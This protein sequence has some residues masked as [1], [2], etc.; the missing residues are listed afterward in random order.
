MH[1]EKKVLFY[2]FSPGAKDYSFPRERRKSFFFSFFP[3]DLLG[4]TAQAAEK[5]IKRRKKAFNAAL[6]REERSRCRCQEIPALRRAIM[7]VFFERK[8]PADV[9]NV[10]LS[11]R[12]KLS[13]FF[14][15][16]VTFPPSLYRQYFWAPFSFADITPLFPK[17][18]KGRALHFPFL[19]RRYTVCHCTCFWRE[20]I[21]AALATTHV[22]TPKKKEREEPKKRE[23]LLPLP[24]RYHFLL[25]FS[26]NRCLFCPEALLSLLR[27]N[28]LFPT[29]VTQHQ[30]KKGTGKWREIKVGQDFG[31][32]LFLPLVTTPTQILAGNSVFASWG[33]HFSPFFTRAGKNCGVGCTLAVFFSFSFVEGKWRIAASRK[34]NEMDYCIRNRSPQKRE[35]CFFPREK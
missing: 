24:T 32:R 3:P 33:T 10:P 21:P 35:N 26:G 16:Y 23:R 19:P 7:P 6:F 20:Q 13:H 2:P 4:E 11:Y 9:S 31:R 14:G 15:A 18:R 12:K 22:R 25:P 34:G 5:W 1:G 8:F 29:H 30:E 27:R 17:E 28:R